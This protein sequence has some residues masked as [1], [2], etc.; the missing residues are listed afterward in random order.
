[1]IPE[2]LESDGVHLN[3]NL[4]SDVVDEIYDFACSAEACANGD[5]SLA[6][7]A[8]DVF[9]KKTELPCELIT[10]TFGNLVER[11]PV[12]ERVQNECRTIQS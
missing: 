5:P 4:P 12:A 1:M 3:V 9:D 6:F 10:G 8:K 11:L 2:G 7:R